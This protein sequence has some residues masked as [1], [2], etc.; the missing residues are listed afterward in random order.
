MDGQVIAAELLKEVEHL[1][2]RR[3]KQYVAFDKFER[4]ELGLNELDVCKPPRDYIVFKSKSE[5]E[6]YMRMATLLQKMGQT[7]AH[8]NFVA[9]LLASHRAEMKEFKHQ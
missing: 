1:R 7:D 2:R 8:K 6:R 9:A 4:R 3:Q 5:E